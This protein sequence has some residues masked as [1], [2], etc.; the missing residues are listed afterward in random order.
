MAIASL[1]LSLVGLV[2]CLTPLGFVGLILGYS[3]RRRIRESRGA[4]GGDGLAT[5]GIVIG[6]INVAITV[7]GIAML[8]LLMAGGRSTY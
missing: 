3:A 1:I 2:S 8:I 4:L 7:L 5:A 6:W